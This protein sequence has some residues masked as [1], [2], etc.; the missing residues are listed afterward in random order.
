MALVVTWV[1]LVEQITQLVFYVYELRGRREVIQLTRAV[2]SIV[3][4]N[5]E[6]YRR[7]SSVS[8]SNT[9]DLS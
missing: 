3:K 1:Q 7:P 5:T 8:M 6:C 2:A 4:L 9:L